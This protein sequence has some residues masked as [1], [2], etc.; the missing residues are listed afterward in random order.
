M[1]QHILTVRANLTVF[2]VLMLLLIVTVAAAYAVPVRF[3][4]FVA[5]T[6]ATI[7]AVMIMMYFMHL[8]FSDRL[9]RIF[10]AAA[11]LWLGILIALSL[12]DYLTRGWLNI[13]GK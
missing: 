13:P 10:A 9:A 7:K 5:L 8:K 2:G 11:F 3:G 4:V 12:N 1:S 6:I